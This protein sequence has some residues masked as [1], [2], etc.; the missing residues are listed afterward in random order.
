MSRLHLASL[1]PSSIST[2]HLP[3]FLP[4]LLRV[5]SPLVSLDIVAHVPVDAFHALGFPRKGTA[6]NHC[7]SPRLVF[8]SPSQLLF[9]KLFLTQQH[10]Q[11]EC[12]LLSGGYPGGS[13]AIPA[14]QM[15]E[16]GAVVTHALLAHQRLKFSGRFR[17]HSSVLTHASFL[18]Q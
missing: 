11:V 7:F 10:E 8:N 5:P 4:G 2:Q 9:S 6:T 1:M 18:S 15:G 14:R 12:P 16:E 3:A 13:E 17:D